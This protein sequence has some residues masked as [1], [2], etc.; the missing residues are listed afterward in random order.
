M[1]GL[2]QTKGTKL[3]AAHF[4]EEFST[5]IDFYRL[6]AH[7]VYFNTAA[8]GWNPAG[9]GG[10][11]YATN[12]IYAKAPH[13]LRTDIVGPPAQGRSL[14]PFFPAATR[15]PNLAKRWLWFLNTS[16]VALGSLTVAND[17][18]IADAIFSALGNALYTSITFDAVETILPQQVA[19]TPAYDDG[20]LYM[21]ISLM[22][23]Q[24]IPAAGDVGTDLPPLD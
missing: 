14:L 17:K 19:A 8:A 22:T 2:I 23:Q 5:W 1:G 16:N 3:L 10:L 21:H 11:L 9:T 20:S 6:P 24:V 15:H 13:S 12:N 4:R 18:A 7:V